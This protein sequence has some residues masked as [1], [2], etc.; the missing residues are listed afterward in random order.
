MV[1][2]IIPT[3]LLICS[4]CLSVSVIA[5]DEAAQVAQEELGPRALL[6][7]YS[8]CKEAHAQLEKKQADIKVYQ[9]GLKS[10]AEQY[11]GV[12]RSKWARED[13]DAY[14]MDS[15]VVAGV[16]A[17]YN[18]LAAQYN[19]KM[20]EVQFSFTNIGTLPRGADVPLPREVAPYSYGDAQ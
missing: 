17:S 11:K 3:L 10:L 6:A 8:W 20:V 16:I 15:T 19:A 13:I 5:C 12:P 1:R 2:A 14:N 18:D 7:K 4:F 9:S